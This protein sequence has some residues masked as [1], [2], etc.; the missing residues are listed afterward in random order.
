MFAAFVPFLIIVRVTK[1]EPTE[2]VFRT[3]GVRVKNVIILVQD[4]RRN[5]E[6]LN[7]GKG[8]KSKYG[9]LRVSRLNKTQY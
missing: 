7:D 9:A 2:R 4:K 6:N 5:A 8:V 3:L 1:F